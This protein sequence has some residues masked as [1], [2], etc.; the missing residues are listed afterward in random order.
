MNV[1]TFFSGIL[2]IILSAAHGIYGARSVFKDVFLLNI[3]EHIK[4]IVFIPW[5]QMTFI[6]FAFGVAQ[7]LAAYHKKL[8]HISLLIL[9][10]IVGNLGTFFLISYLRKDFVVLSTSIVQYV[11]FGILI[12]LTILGIWK[13][14]R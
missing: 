7:V 12:I 2:L 4:T 10:I 11:L 3:P 1:Y 5:H 14:R 6:L 9:I 8:K 13:H